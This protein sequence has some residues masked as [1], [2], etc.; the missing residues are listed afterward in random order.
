MSHLDFLFQNEEPL[1]CQRLF[2]IL[3]SALFH[4]GYLIATHFIHQDL[5]DVQSFCRQ[6]GFFHLSR[7]EPIK[8]LVLWREVYPSSCKKSENSTV[9]VP[10]GKR[11]LLI[12]GSSKVSIEKGRYGVVRYSTVNN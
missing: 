6:Q 12:V 4:A 5:V 1:D 11:Y 3:G 10:E 9:H 8:C 7:T 2:T